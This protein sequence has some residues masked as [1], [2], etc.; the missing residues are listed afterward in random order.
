V[1]EGWL[2]ANFIALIAYYRLF[3]ALKE[4]EL[5]CKYSPADIVEMSTNI[6]KFKIGETWTLS[7]TNKKTIQ[8]FNKLKIDY[9]N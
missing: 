7:E 3:I 4:N 2:M 5:I 6:Y 8:L 1:L 9:L